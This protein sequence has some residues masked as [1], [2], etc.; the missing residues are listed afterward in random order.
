MSAFAARLLPVLLLVHAPALWAQDGAEA[1]S[2]PAD[3]AALHERA[4]E[5]QANFERYREARIPP[6]PVGP[7]GGCDER[8]GRFC[9]RHEGD[10][11]PVPSE[12]P[13]V[14]LA[15]AETLRELTRIAARIPGDRWILGQ[16]VFYLLEAGNLRAAESLA[17]RCEGGARWWCAALRGYVLHHRRR[18]VEA[19]AAFREAIAAMP[20]E[21][22]AEYRSPEYLLDDEG[23]EAFRE[24]GAEGR[25]DL[26]ERLW[27]LSDPLYLVEGN[28]RLTAHWARRTLVRI[29]R[30]GWTPYGI[31]Y[32]EDLSELNVRYGGER[33]WERV[34]SPPGFG[35]GRGGGLRDTRR[36]VGRH[37]PDDR[38]FLPDGA[39]LADPAAIPPGGWT[40]DA[41]KPRTGY[42]APY[43]LKITPLA[44]QVA[45][46]RRGDSTLVVASF[47]ANAAPVSDGAEEETP[48]PEPAPAETG[49]TNPFLPAEPAPPPGVEEEAPE[50]AA[51][52][53]TGPVETGVFLLDG[54]GAPVH[55]KRL[56]TSSAVVTARVPN[57]EYVFGLEVWD[58]EASRAWRTRQGLR[59]DSLAPGQSAVSDLLFLRT[60]GPPPISMEAALPRTLPSIRARAGEGFTVAWEIYG[61]RP[62]EE[63]RVTLG[64]TEGE[65]TFLERVGRFLRLVEEDEPLEIRFEDRA[66]GRLGP[67]F[68]ALDVEIPS[69]EPGV[70]TLR[71]EVRLTGQ[72]PLVTSRRLVVE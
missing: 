19:E 11:D 30:G 55:E 1:D 42:A 6:S 45:R 70:Y 52:G 28:D 17:R 44:A 33:G 26:W 20:D 65:P 56:E 23:R 5:V 32:D 59:Q 22:A 40:L 21:V 53:P 67:V 50:E 62:G 58:P 8:V 18:P 7:G 49:P 25:E 61:L 10:D 9:L 72:T 12:R 4:R 13:E 2:L 36:V 54:S 15:R 3:S 34:M 41:W 39:F 14:A 57:G 46:F 37:H 69:F 38:E 51:G 48:A 31:P 64:F 71:L 47:D 29:R 35:G 43:A 63:A 16:R 68:R 66:P 27:L 60:E 24:A